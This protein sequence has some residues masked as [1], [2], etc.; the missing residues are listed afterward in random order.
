MEISEHIKGLCSKTVGEVVAEDYRRA[1][2][3]KRYGIDFCCGG[4]RPVSEAS[5]EK[6]ISCDDLLQALAKVDAEPIASRT[7]DQPDVRSWPPDFLASYIVNVHHQYVREHAPRLRELTQTVARVHGAQQPEAIQIAQLFH[8]LADELEEHTAKEEQA[9]FPFVSALYAASQN[10]SSVPEDLVPDEA[11]WVE[12]LEDDHDS[13]GALL[14]AIRKLSNDFQLPDGACNTYRIAYA[15]LEAFETDLHRHVH[16]ENNVLFPAA[17][18][19]RQ[20]CDQCRP[21]VLAS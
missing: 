20:E 16:L 19:L 8:Q 6:G 14:R 2:V 13:A 17:E 9:L 10:G 18:R 12:V 5:A 15:E 7:F 4:D 21:R 3:F 11:S 1:D